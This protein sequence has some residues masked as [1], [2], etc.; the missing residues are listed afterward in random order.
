MEDE[1]VELNL[2]FSAATIWCFPSEDAGARFLLLLMI[3]R[4]ALFTPNRMLRLYFIGFLPERFLR[5][6]LRRTFRFLKL[7]LYLNFFD[8]ILNDIFTL[9]PLILHL[10]LY[11]FNLDLWLNRLSCNLCFNRGLSSWCSVDFSWLW[12]TDNSI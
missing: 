12:V 6:S 5:E 9:F 8:F 1:I 4:D 11:F 3:W 10:F 7:L 2:L